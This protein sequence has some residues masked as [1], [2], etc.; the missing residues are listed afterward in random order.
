MAESDLKFAVIVPVYN[1]AD[2]VLKCLWSIKNQNYRKYQL[3]I[4]DN[5]S[6]DNSIEIIENAGYSVDTVK[7]IHKHSWDEVIEESFNRFDAD[8]SYF[9]II[10][11]D[12]HISA[13]YLE[14]LNKILST[15]YIKC[16]QTPIKTN[17][18]EI[19]EYENC[20][21][22]EYK[23]RLTKKCIVTTP[24]VV[25]RVDMKDKWYAKP[26]LYFGYSDYNRYCQLADE[27][28]MVLSYPKYIGYNYVF[29]S[30]QATWGMKKDFPEM[31]DKIRNYWKEK[32]KKDSS[33]ILE[34][35]FGGVSA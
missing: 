35:F 34:K 1:G 13:D 8:V 22:T 29:H 11:C 7:N 17:T 32:W 10:A 20:I 9:T 28:I 24:S 25:Y 23:A 26:E 27:D 16:L 5:E 14:N 2:T 33:L 18:G 15:K 3:I 30:E 19:I 31:E 21:L 4:L 6:T 12:D